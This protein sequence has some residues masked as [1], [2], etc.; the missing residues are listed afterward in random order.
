MEQKG[1]FCF[2]DEMELEDL[3]LWMMI[4]D[5]ITEGN[6]GR[7]NKTYDA[8]KG[9]CFGGKWGRRLLLAAIK[10]ADLTRNLQK[11][12]QR[13]QSGLF[14]GTDGPN[15]AERSIN[16]I[17]FSGIS[18]L[19]EIL[20][21]STTLKH[22]QNFT[23]IITSAKNLGLQFNP[24]QFQKASERLVQSSRIIPSKIQ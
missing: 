23:D 16:Q 5:V 12:T 9:N 3:I 8:R 1:N 20:Q 4:V 2:F 7:R 21:K 17:L 10:S 13:L 22:S 18:M 19:K 14:T 24:E 6:M 11:G 15:S